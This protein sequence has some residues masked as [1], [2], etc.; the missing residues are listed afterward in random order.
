MGMQELFILRDFVL[1]VDK[2]LFT[3]GSEREGKL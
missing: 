3:I 1:S 2:I